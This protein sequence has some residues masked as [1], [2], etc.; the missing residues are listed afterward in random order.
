[1]RSRRQAQKQRGKHPGSNA[2][3]KRSPQL[4]SAVALL[5]LSA[6]VVISIFGVLFSAINKGMT[7]T[8]KKVY[9][10][11]HPVLAGSEC[12]DVVE[13][14]ENFA[15]QNGGWTT[16]RHAAHPTYD[17]PVSDLGAVGIKMAQSIEARLVPELAQ[18]FHLNVDRL[19]IQDLFVAKYSAAAE[20]Q[21]GLNA[22]AD[23]SEYSFVLALNNISA[24]RGGGTLFMRKP[25]QLFRPT[26]GYAT[27]FCGKNRHAGIAVTTGKRY[28]LAGFLKYDE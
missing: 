12:V 7:D 19:S 17:L 13:A 25:K 1:M 24:Y 9:L 16:N 26:V 15:L 6:L 10:T 4:P 14:A 8:Q 5:A 2:Q 20:A 11:S 18:R 22:H 21:A 3:Q 27:L 23:G 28:I